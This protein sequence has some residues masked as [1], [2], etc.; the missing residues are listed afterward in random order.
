MRDAGSSLPTIF[1]RIDNRIS[2]GE[3]ILSPLYHREYRGLWVSL[4]NL[5]SWT[6]S[7][8]GHLEDRICSSQLPR[9]RQ[10]FFLHQIIKESTIKC[11]WRLPLAYKLDQRGFRQISA[12]AIL[13]YC[14]PP[15]KQDV[16][17]Q[18][19]ATGDSFCFCL[20]DTAHLSTVWPLQLQ[21]GPS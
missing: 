3:G 2:L 1:Q 10:T 13:E 17:K 11:S 8:L 6:L 7:L 9:V 19:L 20:A 18:G 5:P 4:L 12:H 21:F 14:M 16:H 15:A